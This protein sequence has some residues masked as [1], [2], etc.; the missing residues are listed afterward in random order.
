MWSPHDLGMGGGGWISWCCRL[1]GKGAGRLW[2]KP[3]W[4]KGPAPL[5]CLL[6]RRFGDF[7]LFFHAAKSWWQLDPLAKIQIVSTRE[8]LCLCTYKKNYNHT[9]S[10][11]CLPTLL[12]ETLVEQGTCLGY[13]HNT[14]QITQ[15]R[16]NT[17]QHFIK[18]YAKLVLAKYGHNIDNLTGDKVMF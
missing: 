9:Y 1:R 12:A 10:S 14:P 11:T 15:G 7:L 2:R 16:S 17:T 5:K 4:W 8:F 6:G 3:L 18:V 13:R